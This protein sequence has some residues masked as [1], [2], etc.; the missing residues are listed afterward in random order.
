MADIDQATAEII[1][2][3]VC[4]QSQKES[5]QEKES[6]SSSSSSVTVYFEKHKIKQQT[7]VICK[8]KNMCSEDRKANMALIT[9]LK[10]TP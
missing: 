10:M 1:L 5:K 4:M 7:V 6:S 2:R 8:H 3:E 9:A